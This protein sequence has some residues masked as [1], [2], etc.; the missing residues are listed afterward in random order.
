[1]SEFQARSHLH[2]RGTTT[3]PWL[4]GS[5][6]KSDCAVAARSARADRATVSLA[7]PLGHRMSRRLFLCC[8]SA[9][10]DEMSQPCEESIVK[11]N[12]TTRVIAKVAGELHDD[13]VLQ[14]QISTGVLPRRR[15][16]P[17]D[18]TVA[19]RHACL[20]GHGKA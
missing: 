1:M 17:N 4:R 15:N 8:P 3:T 19:V 11:S 10:S 5:T 2:M 9:S 6:T 7:P 18:I 14:E 12:L 16:P 13:R 20:F